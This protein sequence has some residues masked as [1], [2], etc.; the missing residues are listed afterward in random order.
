MGFND[1]T[2][3]GL[4]FSEDPEIFGESFTY[5]NT[6]LIGVFSQVE[7]EYR[8][9]EFSMRKIT[10]LVCV[11]SKPQ[12]ETAGLVPSDRETVTYGGIDYPIQQI[13]GANT[14]GEPAY[15]LTLFRLT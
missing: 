10:A 15:T 8:F 5:Q 11:S 13:A 12:W 2:A 14:A 4:S 6:S 1:V 3:A 9:D 7:I